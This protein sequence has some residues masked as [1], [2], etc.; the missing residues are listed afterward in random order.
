MDKTGKSFSVQYEYENNI[1]TVERCF[2]SGTQINDILKEYILKQQAFTDK[3]DYDKTAATL[4]E[5]K[6]K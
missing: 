3:W 4:S 5:G 1:V 6:N 2:K